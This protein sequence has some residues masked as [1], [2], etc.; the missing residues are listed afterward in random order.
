VAK[1]SASEADF[2]VESSTC[3]LDERTLIYELTF[4]SIEDTVIRPVLHGCGQLDEKRFMVSL[5]HGAPK[6]PRELSVECYDETITVQLTPS[7]GV[8]SLPLVSI[9]I[10]CDQPE[11]KAQVGPSAIWNASD[12]V[13]NGPF[14]L[15]EPKNPIEL[16]AQQPYTVRFQI[17]IRC[18][19]ADACLE[20]FSKGVVKMPFVEL[21]TL[22]KQ[23][24]MKAISGER[25]GEGREALRARIALVRTG[26]RGLNGEFGNSIASLCTSDRSDFSCSFFWD[27][28]FSSAAIA[29]FNGEFGR[30]AIETAFTRQS[31][32]DGAAP[33]RKFNF[34][35]P[36]RMLQASPQ[37]PIASW[38]VLRY[39]HQTGDKD[40]LRQIY[41]ALQENHRFWRDHSDVDRDGL[42]EF[43][44]TGQVADNSPIWDSYSVGGPSAF[45]CAWL[46]PVVSVALNSFLYQDAINLSKIAQRL[47]RGDD[48]LSYLQRAEQIQ[49]DL[50]KACYLPEEGRFWDFN[51]ATG[52][53]E[54][55][56]TFYMFWP[57]VC[58]MDV[59]ESTARDLIENVL[60]DPLQFFGDIPFP[61]VPY[62]DPLYK[63]DGYW[64]GRA[65]P[66]ISYWIIEMLWRYGYRSQADEAADRLL[67]LWGSTP[68]YMENQP[69]DSHRN[70]K[71]GFADYNW[72]A[73]A[74]L[75][76]LHRTY[77]SDAHR[78]RGALIGK[79][80]FE[81]SSH[82]PMVEI[83]K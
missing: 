63:A 68:G 26:L 48:A 13:G 81:N 74:M 6:G 20:P 55:T 42:S 47:G 4:C 24:F 36:E 25:H 29:L 62:N 70:L 21:E 19:V 79:Q 61:S 59:P 53:H 77:R 52:S 16:A 75:L 3:F 50:F 27:T 51:R 17:Q 8:S 7:I 66:H 11:W 46:P 76:L 12:K 10:E 67:Y 56:R 31:A 80:S 34:S 22:A 23:R 28:L 44:W 18:S 65:W 69:T 32:H 43:R 37:A 41:H 49:T 38:A 72:G 33:E 15:F 2:S 64:R 60:L 1:E 9:R 39:V 71:K 78:V 83:T 58:G 73:A 82:L 5:Y 57:L 35:V 54:R 45:G 30:G 14:Y 40:F